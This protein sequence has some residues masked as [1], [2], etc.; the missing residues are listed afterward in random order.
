MRGNLAAL[1]V[2]W[3][4]ARTGEVVEIVVEKHTYI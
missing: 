4:G 3:E 2:Q 1:L